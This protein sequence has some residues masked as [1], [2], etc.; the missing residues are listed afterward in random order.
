M[1]QG[2]NHHVAVR[3]VDVRRVLV[4]GVSDCGRALLL[5]HELSHYLTIAH[6]R[7]PPLVSSRLLARYGDRPENYGWGNRAL[8]KI[9]IAMEYAVLAAEKK[10]R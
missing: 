4:E 10:P 5:L 2:V 8:G 7:C 1:E 6:P 3:P 9:R